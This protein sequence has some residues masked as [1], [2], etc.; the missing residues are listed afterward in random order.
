M[1]EMCSSVNPHSDW[2]SDRFVFAN[3]QCICVCWKYN[4]LD[5]I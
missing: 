2:L 1:N 4:G 3:I 5:I